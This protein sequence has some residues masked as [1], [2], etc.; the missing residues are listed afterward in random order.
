M[1]CTETVWA[2]RSLTQKK[3]DESKMEKARKPQLKY[4]KFSNQNFESFVPSFPGV[5]TLTMKLDNNDNQ[6]IKCWYISLRCS[7][8]YL[9]GLSNAGI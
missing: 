2:E 8:W 9:R 1:E 5:S 4:A 6:L 7:W 3:R